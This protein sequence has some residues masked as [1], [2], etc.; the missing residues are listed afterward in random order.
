MT[1]KHEFVEF[2]PNE[3]AVN[4][5]YISI[6]YRTAI[7]KCMCG[8]GVEVVTP[9]LPTYW[10]IT[11]NGETVSFFP[12]I[13]NWS[14]PCRSHYWI[15]DSKVV[16][17]E[18]WS[19]DEIRAARDDNRQRKEEYYRSLKAKE[20]A[21]EGV[22]NIQAMNVNKGVFKRFWHWIRAE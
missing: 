22:R 7:H 6:P 5:I 13:G 16:W 18:D 17:A 20:S 3:L 4:T 12:S 15:K 10:R 19:D 8:C 9:I 21:Q 11:F 2:I 1:I 14:Y